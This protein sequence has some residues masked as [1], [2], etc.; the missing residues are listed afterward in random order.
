[1]MDFPNELFIVVKWSA[2]GSLGC[3]YR[4]DTAL[5]KSFMFGVAYKLDTAL[6]KNLTLPFERVCLCHRCDIR[7]AVAG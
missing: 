2:G 7:D 4:Y 6:H 1:M 3:F 5:S